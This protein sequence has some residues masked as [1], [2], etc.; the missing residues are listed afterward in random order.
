MPTSGHDGIFKVTTDDVADYI[1]VHKPV[2]VLRHD[3]NVDTQNLP[4]MNIGVAKGSTYD[5]VMIFPT[6][7][8]L[9]YLRDGDATKLKS[10]ERL[11]VAVVPASRHID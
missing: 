7:L 10:P 1:A 2:T 4:A 9:E 8:M 3:K 11:Y 5:R 6:N